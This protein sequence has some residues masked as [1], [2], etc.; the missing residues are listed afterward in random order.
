MGCQQSDTDKFLVH[1]FILALV[2]HWK[3]SCPFI[4]I[5]SSL[6]S[7]NYCKAYNRI[8]VPLAHFPSQFHHKD[9]GQYQLDK[10]HLACTSSKWV[11]AFYL[12]K[13]RHIHWGKALTTCKIDNV[14]F[15]LNP[16]PPD[17]LENLSASLTLQYICT[18]T[19]VCLP[20]YLTDG[21]SSNLQVSWNSRNKYNVH[22]K[23]SVVNYKNCLHVYGH[24]RRSNQARQTLLM[25]NCGGLETEESKVAAFYC[26]ILNVLW[27]RHYICCARCP[28][29]QSCYIPL[30]QQVH[31]MESSASAPQWGG[32]STHTWRKLVKD[33][34][35]DT[36]APHPLD[37]ELEYYPLSKDWHLPEIFIN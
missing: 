33:A 13:V 26:Y 20:S 34:C 36:C 19:A 32:S 15:K 2:C 4:H 14:S 1:S 16:S 24:N 27:A 12:V 8:D 6:P 31:T 17:S 10:H 29:L 35:N 30:R 25:G 11:A 7:N 5:G 18:Y 3:V 9:R 22:I 23:F 21:L 28:L 37:L